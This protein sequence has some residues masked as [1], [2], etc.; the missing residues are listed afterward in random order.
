VLGPGEAY[1][2]DSRIPHRF[3]NPA[4]EICELVSACTPPTF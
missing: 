1:Y 3:R 4:D 2:F